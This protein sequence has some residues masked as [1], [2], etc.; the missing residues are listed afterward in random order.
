MFFR[1]N[2]ISIISTS[3]VL[4]FL[5]AASVPAYAFPA[6][7]NED[8]YFGDGSPSG[9]GINT[10]MGYA[11]KFNPPYTPYTVDSISI[12]ISQMLLAP[13]VCRRLQVS[14]LDGTGVRRQYLEIDWRELEGHEGWVLI[15]LANRDY[16]GEFTVILHS[17]V[18]LCPT[19]NI[20]VQ[21]VFK[22][23][24]DKT[25]QASNSY[26]YTS[27]NAPPPPPAGPF[28]DR[29]MIAQAEAN[30]SK[31]VPASTGVPGFDGGNWMIRAHTPGLQMESTRIEITMEDIEAFY[32]VPDIPSPDWHLPP[33][34]GLGPR[35]TVHCPTSFAGVTLYYW[36]DSRERKFIIPHEGPWTHPDLVNALAALCVDLAAEGVIG[37]EHIGIY[38][39]RNIH[40]TNVRSS[41]AYGLGIDISGFQFSDGTVVMVEDHD[42][43]EVRQILEHIRDDYLEKYFTTVIDWNYQRHDNHFHVNLPYPH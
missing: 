34:E 36:Q 15:D 17:G 18:G 30:L 37:I 21:A 8:C 31:L 14:V 33:I 16:D 35:G 20:P 3:L 32:A 2:I 5:T 28:A 27:D 41:H 38:N 43:P 26:A 7:I 4:L 10:W 13:D 6:R 39:D 19:A 42:D 1:I 25:S 23:G 11:V 12:Y 9:D 40:G 22:L 24:I 29:E